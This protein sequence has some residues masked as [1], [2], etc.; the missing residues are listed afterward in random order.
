MVSI[1]LLSFISLFCVNPLITAQAKIAP[2]SPLNTVYAFDMH[3]VFMEQSWT[4]L[5]TSLLYTYHVKTIQ[6]LD[7]KNRHKVGEKYFERMEKKHPSLKGITK[8]FEHF[9]L[10]Q[11]FMHDTLKLIRE[12]KQKGY[13]VYVLS[14]CAQETYDKLQVKYPAVFNLFDGEYLPSKNN[15]YNA[16]P[17][18]SF[19]REFKVY[20]GQQG[21]GSKQIIFIDDK[22]KNVSAAKKENII[23][24]QFTGAKKLRTDIMKLEFGLT[25]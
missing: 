20:L 12:L 22:E 14:N 25:V 21:H 11:P 4:K 16:K 10:N 8:H 23:G 3:K 7:L 19:Y 13:K 6:L 2:V 9:L 1:L 18:S 24:I 15:N 17:H 5:V